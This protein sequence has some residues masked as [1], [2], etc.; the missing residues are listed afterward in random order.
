MIYTK[1]NCEKKVAAS[2]NR[3]GIENF[4][5]MNF[6]EG[7]R[8][9]L[10]KNKSLATPLFG[11][12]LFVYSTQSDFPVIKKVNNVINI[13]YHLNVPAKIAA[14]EVEAIREFTHSYRNIKLEKSRLQVNEVM[15]V[16]KSSFY[17]VERNI[18]S[19]KIDS[20][21]MFL[22]TLG[23]IM[24]A[25]TAKEHMPGEDILLIEK[26]NIKAKSTI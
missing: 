11:P 7:S 3:K 18:V 25:E 24:T 16:D 8:S 10:H 22:P 13:V 20:I 23:Y 26:K 4:C 2:L 17:T 1:P 5:P 19:V 9:T 6:I 14:G 12:Y 15:H 21:K